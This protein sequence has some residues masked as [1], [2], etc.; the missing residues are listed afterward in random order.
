MPWTVLE[1]V[2]LDA[3]VEDGRLVSR[4]SS[5]RVAAQLGVDPTTAA[6]ALRILRQRGFLVLERQSGPA[7]RF[8]LSFYVLMSPAGL[9]V[10][11]PRVGRSI[12]ADSDVDA[13][14]VDAPG[15]TRPG[16]EKPCLGE[17]VTE[18]VTARRQPAVRKPTANTKATMSQGAC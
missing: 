7:G 4:T 17:T 14:P 18:Q 10:I 16:M 11:P 2:A 3:V 9:A 15:L 12:M 5:R 6:N 8:G 1:E 13:S